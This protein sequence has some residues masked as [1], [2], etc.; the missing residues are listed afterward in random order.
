[1][2]MTPGQQIALHSDLKAGRRPKQPLP[3][4]SATGSDSEKEESLEGDTNRVSGAMACVALR[5]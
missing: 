4:A 5:A 3:V 2:T 1:M